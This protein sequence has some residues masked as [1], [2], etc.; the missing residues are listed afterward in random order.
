MTG[1]VQIVI[2]SVMTCAGQL[3]QKQAAEYWRRPATSKNRRVAALA[4]LLAA[5]TLMGLALLLWLDVL[6]YMPVS[7]A[8]P[9][10]SLNFVLVTLGAYLFFR[11]AITFRHCVGVGAIMLGIVLMGLNL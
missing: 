11:E 4:M 2:V 3:C 9:M 1:L 7:V 10:L 6:Q 5:L 8:Y